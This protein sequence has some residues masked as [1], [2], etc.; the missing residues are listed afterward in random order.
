MGIML[1][2]ADQGTVAVLRPVI[3]LTRIT[4][5]NEQGQPFLQAVGNRF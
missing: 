1:V 4:I 2:M 5:V 3:F